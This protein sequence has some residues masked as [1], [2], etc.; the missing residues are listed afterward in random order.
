MPTRIPK[1]K[2]IRH[3]GDQNENNSPHCSST[4]LDIET[5]SL[6]EEQVDEMFLEKET[7]VTQ[8]MKYE[9]RQ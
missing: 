3:G 2:K 5:D 1:K 6:T 4:R 8:E 9:I 7:E